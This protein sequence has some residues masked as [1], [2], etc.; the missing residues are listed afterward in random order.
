MPSLTPRRALL[1]LVLV[2]LVLRL[3]WAATLGVGND[4]AYY[5]LFAR[6]PDWSYFDHPP[7]TAWVEWLGLATLGGLEPG[8]TPT[9]LALRIG[10]VG[11]FAI[12]TALLARL[13]ARFFGGP[14]GL[15]AAVL[16][17]ATAYF[18]VVAGAF[19]MPDGPLIACWLLALDRLAAAVQTPRRGQPWYRSATAAWLLVGL[20]WGGALL[21]KYH[22]IFLP[23]AALG[24][25]A[26]EPLARPWL[27][28]PGPYLALAVAL[29]LFAPVLGWNA[30]HDW[31]SFAFQGSRA[32]GSAR[33][34]PDLLAT[35]ILGQAAYILP[36]I[37]LPLVACL[38]RGLWG[39]VRRRPGGVV[40]RSSS[41]RWSGLRRWTLPGTVLAGQDPRPGAAERFLLAQ[42]VPP[43][44]GFL[45]VACRQ[46]VL[47]H[48]SLVG[49]LPLFPLVG[50][51]WATWGALEPRALRRRLVGLSV[52]P[53]LLA[54]GVLG[55][56]HFGW[57]QK[58]G[59]GTLGLLKPSA[60]PTLDLYGWDQV[61]AELG[62]RGLL[63][64]PDQFVFTSKWFHSGQLAFATGERAPVL[65]YS[66]RKSLGFAQFSPPADWVGRDG[67]L[68]VVNH[69]STE[70][71]A[72][73]DWFERIEP[74]GGFA[75][76]RAGAPVKTV[77]LYRCVRQLRPFPYAPGAPADRAPGAGARL[78]AGSASPPGALSR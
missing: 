62:R 18:G 51:D 70:P 50:R 10:F 24:Y 8:S 15:V 49:L 71:D 28:R 12:T 3:A 56:T 67:V 22:G 40:P 58:D 36:W 46:P 73:H 34:R 14:A 5:F 19:A 54:L 59:P 64:R 21:S 32:L 7:A 20:A 11:L 61:A 30:A 66:Q 55:Q 69:S 45:L 25:L 72:F 33:L 53:V 26:W 17:N 9:P 42:A 48:W 16:L 23:L 57:L 43:L 6:H 29:L 63:D 68:V 78:A 38:G 13:T 39:L 77:R 52:V 4:E 65:C 60:D 2:A 41:E 47:P 75:I 37:W 31:A 76:E 44:L 1:A 27:R 35:A 74:L